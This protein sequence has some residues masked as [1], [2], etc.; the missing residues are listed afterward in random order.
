MAAALNTVV[1]NNKRD[2]VTL[3][4]LKSKKINFIFL[5]KVLVKVEN[6]IGR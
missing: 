5:L 1:K 2:G 4:L 3:S 6:K